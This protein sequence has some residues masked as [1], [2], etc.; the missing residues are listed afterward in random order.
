M[1]FVAFSHNLLFI[2]SL[3]FGWTA[4]S[5]D[6]GQNPCTTLVQGKF[7]GYFSS[8]S[9]FP[10]NSSVC[11]WIIQNPDPRRYTLYM[12]VSKP[13]GICDHQQIR[14]SQ[15]D[16]FLE[17]T[18]TYLGMESFDDVLKLCDSSV[19]YAFLQSSKQ[20]LQMK[21]TV[22]LLEGAQLQ[23][24]SIKP[25]GTDF[26]LE[27]LVLGNRNPSKA[28]CQMLCK[29]LDTCLTSSSSFHPCGIMQT[30]CSCHEGEVQSQIHPSEITGLNKKKED[31][32]KD[33]I[34]LENCMSSSKGVGEFQGGLMIMIPDIEIWRY[35]EK[36]V[37]FLRLNF[38]SDN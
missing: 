35:G 3:F 31:C 33:G 29:W 11:S 22:P 30:P 28:A 34:Y 9:V 38:G 24:R 14:T 1:R 6:L 8:S 26:S 13:S 5:L 25:Q 16:S 12:K 27:Y 2:F 15:F 7:F 18:R 37:V 19:E 4:A 20:F 10:L 36:L 32:F 17:S 21:Q 23:W